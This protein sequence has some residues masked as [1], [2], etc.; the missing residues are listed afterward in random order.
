MNSSHSDE[1]PLCIACFKSKGAGKVFHRP[2]R[3]DAGMPRRPTTGVWRVPVGTRMM[4]WLPVAASERR[5]K[6]SDTENDTAPY[7][8][9]PTSANQP[10]TSAP[11]V[12]CD[13]RR[14]VLREHVAQCETRRN[15]RTLCEGK[16]PNLFRLTTGHPTAADRV[17]SHCRCFVP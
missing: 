1:A 2:V 11:S 7:Q 4:E 6:S 13:G 8:L 5:S 12:S 9:A 14:R 15:N 17:L 10:R 3:K 16:S